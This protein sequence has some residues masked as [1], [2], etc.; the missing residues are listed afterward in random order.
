MRSS[1]SPSFTSPDRGIAKLEDAMLVS[2]PAI[3]DVRKAERIW[4]LLIGGEG[5]EAGVDGNTALRRLADRG[6]ENQERRTEVVVDRA[7]L[8]AHVPVVDV[9]EEV[10]ADLNVGDAVDLGV[11][12]VGPGAPAGEDGNLEAC[13]FESAPDLD[14]AAHRRFRRLPPVLEAPQV[15]EVARIGLESQE[16][17]R[18]ALADR[19]GEI[20]GGLPHGDAR[21]IGPDVE[22]DEDGA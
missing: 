6:R 8:S 18:R 21:P 14:R 10:G 17:Q 4:R 16:P 2:A 19:L 11:D 7:V 5:L 15:L 20:E 22:I 9:H 12:V 13:L 1:L 3:G